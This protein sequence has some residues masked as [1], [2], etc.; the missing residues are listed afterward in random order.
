MQ[1]KVSFIDEVALAKEF[2]TDDC[3]RK[4]THRDVYHSPYVGRVLY[5]DQQ[6]G[7]VM[8]QWP[9]G[10]EHEQPS[11]LIRDASEGALPPLLLDQLP[12][13]VER[14]THRNSDS[15]FKADLKYRKSL[16]TTTNRVAH[17]HEYEQRVRRIATRFEE[18]TLPLKRATCLAFHSGQDEVQAFLSVSAKYAS[19]FGTEPIRLTVSNF[20]EIA[21]RVAIYWK[22]TNRRYKVTNKERAEGKL[23]CPR[24][25]TTPMKPRAYRHGKKVLCCK[26][27]GFTISPK[28]LV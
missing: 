2:A 8:V 3:V 25:G 18:R 19:Q 13:T 4:T 5:S 1:V 27:C 16:G 20:Y 11:E 21:R 15:D 23:K 24:C 28:D 22:D 9:W 26:S 6:T 7:K 12:L 10:P 17:I 14:Q